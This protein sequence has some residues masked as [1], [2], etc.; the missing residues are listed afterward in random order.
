MITFFYM[1][2]KKKKKSSIYKSI[3]QLYK[4]EGGRRK[5]SA[6]CGGGEMYLSTLFDNVS[7]TICQ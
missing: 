7:S 4:A 5:E 1:E 3:S 2:K 6:V